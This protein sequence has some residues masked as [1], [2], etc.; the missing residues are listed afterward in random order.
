M[1]KSERSGDGEDNT[2]RRSSRSTDTESPFG[3]DAAEWFAA[4]T[5]R[6]GLALIGIVLLLFALGQVAGLDLL[7]LVVDALN[8]SIGRW[9]LVALFAL[10]LIAIAVRGFGPFSE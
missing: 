5:L 4:S 1:S 2:E 3:E 9:L 10:L 7:G 8:S 6:V